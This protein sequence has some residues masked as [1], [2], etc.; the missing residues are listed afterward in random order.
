M[1]NIEKLI[2]QSLQYRDL[3]DEY[4]ALATQC[5]LSDTEADR[6]QAILDQ[7]ES[8]PLLYFLIDEI[9]HCLAH[10]QGLI[11]AKFIQNQQERLHKT[12]DQNRLEQILQEIQARSVNFTRKKIEQCQIYLHKQVFYNG[13]I[14]GV[15]GP[16][17]KAAIDLLQQEKNIDFELWSI[18]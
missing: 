10:Q 13:A 2:Q 14:D 12:M 3:I 11:D 18:C 1:N 8:E 7:A 9:D 5:S 15:Y 16:K 4:A 17:T 6:I